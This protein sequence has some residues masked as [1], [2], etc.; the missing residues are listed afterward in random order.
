MLSLLPNI[1]VPNWLTNLSIDTIKSEPFPLDQVLQDS[2]FYPSSGFDG[3]PVRYLA[4]NILSFIYVDYGYSHEE[5][6][7]ALDN[8]GFLGYDLIANRSVAEKE[9]TPRGWRPTPPT[10][11]DGAP[12]RYRDWIKTPFCSWLLFQRSEDVSASH[13]PYRFSLL[14][15][16]ADGAAAFQALY[17]ANSMA[18]KVVAVIQPGHGFGGNWTNFEDPDQVFARSV[19]ENPVGIPEFLLF[20]GIGRR[21]DYRESCWSNYREHLCFLDKA[22]G[23]TIGLWGRSA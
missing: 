1:A 17:V 10:G 13:G 23:G 11:S 6:M 5:F 3:D 2:L 8:P 4:G 20:G 14:Y 7:N 18:P 19:L 21:N 16:C 22:G 12:P 9:L 15:L